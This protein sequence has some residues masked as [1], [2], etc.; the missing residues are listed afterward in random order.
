[1]N[2]ALTL[3]AAAGMATVAYAQSGTLFVGQEGG[4]EPM[5]RCDLS[6]F[7]SV[8]YTDGNAFDVQGAAG[9]PAGGI[10]I[11]NGFFSS[12]LYLIPPGGSTPVYRTHIG[13]GIHGLGYVNN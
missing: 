10:Y 12:D 6:S 13:I 5:R 3:I 4:D 2:R 11:V 8:S 7:P 9:T 1:M